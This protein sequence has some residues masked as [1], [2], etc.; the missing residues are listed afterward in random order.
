MS[1]K[2]IVGNNPEV[3]ALDSTLLH[4][5]KFSTTLH[6]STL[7]QLRGQY[8]E[9]GYLEHGYLEHGYLEHGL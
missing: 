2:T 5:S 9:H 6:K 4:P 8:S 7:N 3:E 1:R